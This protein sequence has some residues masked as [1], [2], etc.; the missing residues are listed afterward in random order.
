MPV[1]ATKAQ[2]YHLS[3]FA[4]DH[5]YTLAMVEDDI[6]EYEEDLAKAEEWA[7]TDPSQERTATV[8]AIS[9]HLAALNGERDRLKRE[10]GTA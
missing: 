10:E 9:D 2:A 8:R 6:R 4:P 5:E 7:A 3:D 1:P